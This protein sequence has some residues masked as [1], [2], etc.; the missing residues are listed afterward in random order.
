MAHYCPNCGSQLPRGARFC[1]HCGH[2][3]EGQHEPEPQD[4]FPRESENQ[5]Y[6][7]FAIASLV[8]SL[9]LFLSF[10]G[11]VF[12]IV[13]LIRIGKDAR[14]KGSWMAIAGIMIG[15]LM[16]V[17]FLMVHVAVPFF[18]HAGANDRLD[19]CEANLKQISTAI[20][21]YAVDNS[22]I[23]PERLSNVFPEYIEKIPV[24]PSSRLNNSYGYDVGSVTGV[25]T[26]WCTGKNAH[27]GAGL[28]TGFPQYGSAKEIIER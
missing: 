6:D 3:V 15:P 19:G 7:G 2:A 18:I 5:V 22:R 28:N 24:C 12:G 25:Y 21:A 26:I 1:P 4:M 13:S 8:C 17:I 23:Y 27:H 16:G 20:E 9:T 10:L 14:L 11:L